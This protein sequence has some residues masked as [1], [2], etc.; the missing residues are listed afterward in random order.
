MQAGVKRFDF[1]SLRDF[2]IAL[3]KDAPPAQE[4][5]P[6]VE[7]AP[8]P[9]PPPTFSE[10][11]LDIAKAQAREEGYQKGL[12]EGSLRAR[13]QDADREAQLMT[14]MKQACENI[15]QFRAEYEG[16][17]AAHQDS[18]TRLAVAVARHVSGAAMKTSPETAVAHMVAECLPMLLGEPR[19]VITV[20]PSI[21]T[22]MKDKLEEVGRQAGYDGTLILEPDETLNTTD[23]HI[24]WRSGSARSSSEETWRAIE[25]KL[26]QAPA[27]PEE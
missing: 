11:E 6:V 7:V 15:T 16:Y 4:P 3:D 23:C 1:L 21:I 12:E 9:P 18:L 19:I 27:S 24:Q 26:M 13:R 20:H 8:P 25:E 10:K 14:I 2:G 22:L 5:L 17:V